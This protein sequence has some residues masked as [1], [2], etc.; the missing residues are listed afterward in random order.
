ML[1]VMDHPLLF[2]QD[3]LLFDNS[4]NELKNHLKLCLH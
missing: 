3:Q 1:H 4:V 2:F